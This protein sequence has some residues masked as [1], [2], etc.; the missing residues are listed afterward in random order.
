MRAKD[1]MVSHVPTIAGSASIV[2]GVRMLRQNFGDES[3]LN[4]APGLVVLNENET[5][6]GI[7]SPLCV[8]KALLATAQQD[9][10]P[11]EVTDDFLA[12]LCDS[13]GDKRVEDVMDWQPIW[14][15]E[16]AS[17]ME[18]AQLFASH[19]FQRLPVV[20]DGKVVGIIYRSRLLFAMA[21][22]MLP[23]A[24]EPAVQIAG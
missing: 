18:I 13:I 17:V 23:A 8:I 1:V 3:F 5:I 4:A 7:L 21:K 14:V 10:P 11:A 20:A 19:L 2:E 6:I 15:T 22:C 16:E 12:A 9:A 24:E